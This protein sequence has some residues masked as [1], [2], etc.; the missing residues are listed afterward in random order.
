MKQRILGY[1]TPPCHR[2]PVIA[3][4]SSISSSYCAL[5]TTGM[6]VS[7][8]GGGVARGGSLQGAVRRSQSAPHMHV[9][10]CICNN[11]RQ[12]FHHWPEPHPCIIAAICKGGGG[13]TWIG[14]VATGAHIMQRECSR[15][16]FICDAHT[17]CVGDIECRLTATRCQA[18][19]PQDPVKDPTRPSQDKMGWWMITLPHPELHT[20]PLGR[21]ATPSRHTPKTYHLT[22]IT[23]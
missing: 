7:R 18:R 4:Q 10:V 22:Y 14:N 1:R 21:H 5:I 19:L 13:G 20:L 15:T 16:G 2:R 11:V 23:C 6:T 3:T 9:L 17:C 8:G 12:F